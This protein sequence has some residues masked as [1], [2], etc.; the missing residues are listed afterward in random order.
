[1]DAKE[2]IYC[3]VLGTIFGGFIFTVQALIIFFKVWRSERKNEKKLNKKNRIATVIESCPKCGQ[4]GVFREIDYSI[5]EKKPFRTHAF[6]CGRCGYKSN[7]NKTNLP[8]KKHISAK[9]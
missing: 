8:P 7:V 5:D 2:I 4:D 3:V 9:S 1:M 6:V